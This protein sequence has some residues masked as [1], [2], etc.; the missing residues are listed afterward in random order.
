[1]NKALA[2]E[3]ARELNMNPEKVYE[4]CKSFHDGIRELVHHPA[5]CKAGIMIEEFLTM[6]IKEVKIQ[7]AIDKH[8][9]KDLDL[10]IEVKNNLTKYKRKKYESRK[11]RQAES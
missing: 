7:M 10:K 11:K 8:F 1:M 3:V 5:D 4:I 9:V 2:L 6:R